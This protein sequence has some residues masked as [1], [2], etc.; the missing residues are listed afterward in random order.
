MHVN[1]YYKLY[2]PWKKKTREVSGSVYCNTGK[3]PGAQAMSMFS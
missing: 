3:C 1:F 2:Q